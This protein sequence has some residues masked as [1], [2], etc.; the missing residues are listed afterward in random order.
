MPDNSPA[1]GNTVDLRWSQRLSAGIRTRIKRAV[2]ELPRGT[3]QSMAVPGQASSAEEIAFWKRR[4]VE[5]LTDLTYTIRLSRHAARPAARPVPSPAGPLPVRVTEHSWREVNQK[6]V[7]G[8][9]TSILKAE[10]RDALE[11]AAAGRA[12]SRIWGSRKMLVRRCSPLQLLI[13]TH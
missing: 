9:L 5:E 7:V 12:P 11:Q 4:A 1:V 3:P 10:D 13:S 8:E 2:D 6:A